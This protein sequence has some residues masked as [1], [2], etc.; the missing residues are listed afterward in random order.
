VVEVA[1]E[2]T[3][4]QWQRQRD[5]D[6][7]QREVRTHDRQLPGD[8]AAV[9]DQG[10]AHHHGNDGAEIGTDR[11]QRGGDRIDRE[12]A[13]RKDRAEGRANQQTLET[14]GRSERA[15][16]LLMRQDFGN[17]RAK[18]ATG[19][20]SRQDAAEQAEVM[21]QNLKH[22]VDTVAAPDQ[23]GTDHDQHA[24]GDHRPAD[25][26]AGSAIARAAVS[27]LI[28]GERC[29]QGTIQQGERAWSMAGN[30]PCLGGPS[31]RC[32]RK[33]D[34]IH[35]PRAGPIHFTRDGGSK[36]AQKAKGAAACAS[37]P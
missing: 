37:A 31:G 33:Y 32:K 14:R 15:R 26:L 8:G 27:V 5:H 21:R 29:F 16:D 30:P 7:P 24:D 11:E 18:K 28:R 23:R 6:A 17:E 4:K 3:G 36:A 2:R 9:T 13:A 25:R 35:A 22:A 19:E 20:N 10:P 34:A 1:A 12:G